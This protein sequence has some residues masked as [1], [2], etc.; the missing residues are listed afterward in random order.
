MRLELVELELVG[1]EQ[2]RTARVAPESVGQVGFARL[3]V[4]RGM[5][6]VGWS[7][8]VGVG[9]GAG[10]GPLGLRLRWRSRRT[11]STTYRLGWIRGRTVGRVVRFGSN[12]QLSRP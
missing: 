9:A 8:V 4:G 5:A 1:P 6:L 11:P 12:L 10:S 7:P 3:L 2:T